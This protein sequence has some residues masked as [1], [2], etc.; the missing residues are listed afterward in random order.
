MLGQ[1]KSFTYH[2][3]ERHCRKAGANKVEASVSM[4]ELFRE[5]FIRHVQAYGVSIPEVAR[6]TGVSKHMLH[7]L[8][9]RK[10]VVPNVHDATL[11]AKFFGKTIEEFMEIP[12]AG[13][14]QD[15]LP[16]LI[17]QLDPSEREV[18]EAQIDVLLRRRKAKS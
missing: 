8:H 17:S 4:R 2:A 15:R 18:L 3:S 10:T 16:S 9:Q 11:V 6:A 1:R 12:G 5:S 14:V 7:A 13:K